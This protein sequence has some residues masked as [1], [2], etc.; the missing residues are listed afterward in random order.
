MSK[1][2]TSQEKKQARQKAMV[3]DLVGMLEQCNKVTENISYW[4][5][6]DNYKN[7][8]MTELDKQVKARLFEC[9][10]RSWSANDIDV[11][12]WCLSDELEKK[13]KDM[14]CMWRV[15]R[16]YNK[17]NSFGEDFR[18]WPFGILYKAFLEIVYINIH[19]LFSVRRRFLKAEK[20]EIA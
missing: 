14:E 10:E 16:K 3:F 20:K 11:F 2:Q 12:L 18:L 9:D 7:T 6:Y 5:D 4:D 1:I 15:I 17:N 13:D 8:Y 19:T